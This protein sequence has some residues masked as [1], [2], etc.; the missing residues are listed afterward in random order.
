MTKAQKKEQQE[1]CK[2]LREYLKPGMTVWTILDHVSRSGMTRH[3]RTKVIFDN[4]TTLD[5][6]YSIATALGLRKARKGD[7][8]VVS[9]CGMDM[10]FHLTYELS[11]VL[12]PDGFSCTGGSRSSLG[13]CPSNDHSNGDR[14]YT[15]HLHKD[16]GYALRHAW[17]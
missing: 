15:P 8:L 7:G 11:S 16:G 9:G 12:F 5:P 2:H 6:N 3:I 13:S 10:G 14:D 17:L 4:G 1:A